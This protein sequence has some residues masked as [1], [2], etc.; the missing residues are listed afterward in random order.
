MDFRFFPLSLVFFFF[1]S[2]G[3]ALVPVA[4]MLGG[5]SFGL[6]AS[7]ANRIADW[8]ASSSQHDVG[9]KSDRLAP[10]SEWRAVKI[11]GVYLRHD[12]CKI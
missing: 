1:S 5:G 11:S 9:G 7:L 8:I 4:M 6:C 3:R 10:H 2:H 12:W